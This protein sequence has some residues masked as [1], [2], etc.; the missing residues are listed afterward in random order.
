[1]YFKR[2][3]CSVYFIFIVY[4]SLDWLRFKS[5]MVL[6]GRVVIVLENVI[7]DLFCVW[8]LFS[9]WNEE[10]CLGLFGVGGGLGSG[11]MDY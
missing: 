3:K 5:G 6:C 7:L 1:M 4:F 10:A 8:D 2:F 11:E 9:V